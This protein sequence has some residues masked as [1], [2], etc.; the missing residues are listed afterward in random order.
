MCDTACGLNEEIDNFYVQTRISNDQ[1]KEREHLYQYIEKQV[2]ILYNKCKIE[3]KVTGQNNINNKNKLEFLQN[4]KKNNYTLKWNV[5]K[6]GSAV[7]G[8]NYSDSDIDVAIDL[9]FE[10]NHYDKK[11]VL[12]EL[13][14]IILQYNKLLTGELLLH[15]RY[16]I[17]QIYAKLFNIRFD[18][19]IADTFCRKTHNYIS[20]CIQ[21]FEEKTVPIKKLIIFV[22]YWAKQ[23]DINNSYHLYLNSFGYTLLVIKYLQLYNPINKLLTDLIFQFFWCYHCIFDVNKHSISIANNSK[24]FDIKKDK[25]YLLE[26]VDP[27][28]SSNNVAKNVGKKQWDDIKNAFDTCYNVLKN[29]INYKQQSLFCLLMSQ[30]QRQKTANRKQQTCGIQLS[31]DINKYYA[32]T[33]RDSNKTIE[34]E[35][36]CK[37]ITECGEY[38][39]IRFEKE[40]NL[41]QSKGKKFQNREKEE[42]FYGMSKSE[43]YFAKWDTFIFGSE[44]WDTSC[45]DSII[46][47]A[48]FLNF[49][50]TLEMKIYV[51]SELAK[52]IG[53]NDRDGLLLIKSMLNNDY[54]IIRVTQ[55]KLNIKINISIADRFCKKRNQWMLQVINQFENVYK[56]PIKK[57]MTFIKYWS[58]QKQINDSDECFVD[59]YTILCVK[60]L[61]YY[62]VNNN[63]HK[64]RSLSYCVHMFFEFCHII[65]NP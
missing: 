59:L 1:R 56:T 34:K 6:F 12:K 40:M 55:I 13:F 16:P 33:R 52:M 36:L 53:K 48:I 47:M 7:L 45:T 43:I 25:T 57:L 44:L 18:I 63:N 28:N 61:Q 3:T 60:A 11:Y 32:S 41:K 65:Y 54:P 8:T 51:L 20:Q 27:V 58:K 24:V 50:N 9:N 10:C 22:K 5:F 30:S 21:Q 37:Y 19:S 62:I 2:L 15:A 29:C 23:H 4:M 35:K 39:Q 49:K 26:I 64:N 14:H 42:F 46:D 31:V 38:L 17:I